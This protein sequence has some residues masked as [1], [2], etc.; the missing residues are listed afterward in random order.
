MAT[1]CVNRK[2]CFASGLRSFEALGEEGG[3]SRPQLRIFSRGENRNLP[4]DDGLTVSASATHLR[5]T[6]RAVVG[7]A[8]Q[9][10]APVS[11]AAAA[12]R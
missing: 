2:E 7:V 9:S 3:S 6:P 5:A 11:G 8:R 1:T 4:T 12:K 10:G